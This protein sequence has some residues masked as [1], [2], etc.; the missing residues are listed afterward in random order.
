MS[1]YYIKGAKIVNEGCILR[2]NIIVTGEIIRDIT[3]NESAVVPENF[4]VINAE[5]LY[6]F[7][8]VIDSHVHFREP[9]LTEKGTIFTESRA[10]VAGG[11]TTYFDM[12]NTVP[13]ATSM[14]AVEE[15]IRLASENSLANFSFYIGA[16][17]NNIDELAGSSIMEIC[18]IKVFLGSSTGNMICNDERSLEKLFEK[19]KHIIAV[20]SEDDSII[21]RNKNKYSL[22]GNSGIPYNIHSLIR[23]EEACYSTTRK[24]VE[25][26][27]KHGTRLHLLHLS[28]A[29]ELEFLSDKPVNRDKRIT[30][31]ACLNH[32]WFC[33]EDYKI[34]G[35][36]LKCNPSVKS[37]YNR[38]RIREAVANGLIDVVSTDH[39][40]HTIE[41][42]NRDYF[43]APSGCPFIEH[44]LTAM[45]ELHLMGLFSLELI[46]DKMC[47]SPAELFSVKKRGFI[48]KS[49]FADLV[50]VDLT[51]EQT[52][53]DSGV[54]YKCK[55]TPLN[56]TNMRSSVVMTFVNG[57]I[58]YNNGEFNESVKGKPVEFD[59]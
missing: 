3:D 26:A 57:E 31:E 39:A 54:H 11:I 2:K 15:K 37:S 33:E 44:S 55:W 4:I 53:L 59:R 49:Y 18:G 41:E 7:P 9:G 36:R 51:R 40:P 47:H 5:G 45:L 58:V 20:H 56:G 42:K 28:T 17:D 32:L 52:I 12:P 50:L 25:F 30:S 13:P 10:A 24:A 46:A 38:D 23:N 22:T 43:N 14:N 35:N 1:S 16:S 34:L 48:R 21:T 19:S 6:L 27:L 8:G 29:A